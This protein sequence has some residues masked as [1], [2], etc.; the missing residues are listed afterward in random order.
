[1]GAS[2][3][4]QQGDTLSA[5]AARAGMDWRQL[6]ALNMDRIKNPN[7]SSTA[8]AYNVIF[9]GTVLRLTGGGASTSPAPTPAQQA[10]T[11][12]DEAV[13]NWN[14]N[15]SSGGSMWLWLGVALVSAYVVFSD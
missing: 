7:P 4:V 12:S 15:Q 11:A 5:I 14:R 8:G 10:V 2:Y 13:V 3:T 9:P 1:M 6:L